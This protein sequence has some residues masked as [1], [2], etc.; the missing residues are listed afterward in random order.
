MD[1]GKGAPRALSSGEGLIYAVRDRVEGE[2]QKGEA[3]LLDGGVE[4]KRL[5]VLEAEL[6]GVLK[7]MSREGNTL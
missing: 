4:D 1:R 5:L 2:N 3:V 6:A 7:V